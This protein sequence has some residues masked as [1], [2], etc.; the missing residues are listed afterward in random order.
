MSTIS[1]RSVSGPA[2]A[3][4]LS[5]LDGRTVTGSGAKRQASCPGQGHWR[6]DIHPSLSVTAAEGKVV[7]HC[8]AGCHIDDVLAGLGLTAADLYDDP[9]ASRPKRHSEVGRALDAARIPDKDDKA[10][11]LML[12]A[13]GFTHATIADDYH[14][15]TTA[16][17][18]RKLH[19]TDRS[20]QRILGNLGKH[21]WFERSDSRVPGRV[22]GRLSPGESYGYHSE[23]VCPVDGNPL[24]SPRSVYCSARCTKRAERDRKR[25]KPQADTNSDTASDTNSDKPQFKGHDVRF[26]VGQPPVDTNSDTVRFHVGHVRHPA[27]TKPRS[28]AELSEGR[29]EGMRRGSRST[30]DLVRCPFCD[31]VGRGELGP[32]K[33]K[34]DCWRGGM[35]AL[36]EA[37]R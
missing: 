4:V 33:H 6:G 9:Q 34:P 5:A 1:P 3:R 8:H 15:P 37:E 29:K 24:P 14:A 22:T 10:V 12:K 36:Y 23:G 30:G 20:V 16:S 13:A 21:G 28:E 25:N 17:L 2:F 19:I 35:W 32:V 31:E 26:P 7:L 11:R 18:A 27:R